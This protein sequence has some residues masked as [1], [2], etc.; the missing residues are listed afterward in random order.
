M[1]IELI[2]IFAL[3]LANA[4]FAG[5]EIAIIALQEIR[6]RELAEKG[7]KS[8]R[9]VL[10]LRANPERFLATV[11]V[12]ITVVGAT[13]AALGGRSIATRISPILARISPEHADDIALGIVIA[14]VSF[15][16]IVVGELVPKSLA[17]RKAE[18]FALLVG[19]L[20]LALSW[21][22]R[23][24]VWILTASSNLLLRPFGDRTTF[25]ETRHSAADLQA[26]VSE[27]AKAGT[28]HP[29]AGE[30]AS[31]A[32]DL[33]ELTAA[34]VMIPRGEVV[35]LPR[36]ASA[37]QIRA[38]LLENL[39]S[40]LPVYE[41]RVDNVVG[42]V[43]VKDLLALAWEQGLIILEDLMRPP[44]FVPESIKA[45]DLL[46]EM[47]RRHTPFAIVVDE[48]GG[49]SGI[50]TMEDLLE[51]LVGDIFSEHDQS[52]PAAIKRHDDG[53]A[54]V[55]GNAPIRDVNRELGLDLPED[56][57]W[58][59]LAG[60]CLAYARKIPTVGEKI[61]VPGGVVLEIVDV[62]PR[63]IRQVRVHP[64]VAVPEGSEG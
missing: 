56:G 15:M 51:E 38:I 52:A 33:P 62:T 13:A 50:V 48:Q 36:H 14:G 59:T 37:E 30:I 2:V 21:I 20:L 17:L 34:D 23:P 64:A 35:M 55:A 53:S 6:L 57:D 61:A 19:R 41:D 5:A 9:A 32:L 12:G 39:Y 40:R 26:L 45:M 3:I 60:L 16:S 63:S 4:F 29:D 47:R 24:F 11:Q 18:T 1:L 8:A 28:V 42:Y 22:T 49:M 43:S 58:S 7:R 44:F 25:A 31:R 27:A 54:T 46:Q 10:A